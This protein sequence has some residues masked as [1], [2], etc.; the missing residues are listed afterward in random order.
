MYRW[1]WKLVIVAA[2]MVAIASTSW[3]Q[4]EESTDCENACYEAE[5]S[6]LATCEDQDDPMTCEEDCAA[7]AESC[8]EKCE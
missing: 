7:A 6:C 4:D 3:A 2:A 1:I 8:S 5:A